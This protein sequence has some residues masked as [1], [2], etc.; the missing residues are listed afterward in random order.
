MKFS[1]VYKGMGYTIE[2]FSTPSGEFGWS[3]Q[4]DGEM[5]TATHVNSVKTE[6]AAKEKGIAWAE[7]A[8]NE[9]SKRR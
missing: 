4:L 1:E 3:G 2:V 9:N 8:I 6:E 5:D 7:A